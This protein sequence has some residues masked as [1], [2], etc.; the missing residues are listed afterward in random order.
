MI[1]RRFLQAVLR[2][3][4]IDV[5]RYSA[6]RSA[7]WRRAA[8]LHRLAVDLV[9]DA[10][11]NVGD[12]AAELRRSGYTGRIVCFEPVASVFAV[13]EARS[14]HDDAWECHRLALGATDG[15]AVINVGGSTRTSSLL[16]LAPGL[17][18][19]DDWRSERTELVRVATL[20]S[21]LESA[22]RDARR[23]LLKLD[24]QGAELDVLAGAPA[25]IGRVVALEVELPLRQFYVGQPTHRAIVDALDDLGF[26]AVSIEPGYVEPRSGAMTYADA[27]FARPD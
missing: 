19:S 9:V 12:Y 1:G 11:A 18:A 6:T 5:R 3:G 10:G 16:A 25:A 20:D 27:L 17:E 2:R 7:S 4:G 14:A 8:L 24:V 15:E 23:V 13:L 21:L 22:F 26:G